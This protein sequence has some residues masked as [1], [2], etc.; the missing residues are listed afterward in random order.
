[1]II[2]PHRFVGQALVPKVIGR[3]DYSVGVDGLVAGRIMLRPA[4]FGTSRWFWSITGPALV[5]AELPSSGEADSLEDA[6]VAFREMYDRWLTWAVAQE[7]KVHWM[8][9]PT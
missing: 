3:D 5:Q 4:A 6:R 2:E 8:G 9:G 1:M 7:G